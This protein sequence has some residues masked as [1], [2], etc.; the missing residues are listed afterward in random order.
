[1]AV[2]IPSAAKHFRYFAIVLSLMKA[3]SLII[4]ANSKMDKEVSEEGLIIVQHVLI[5][6]PP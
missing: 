4:R 2:D 5:L 6:K 1:M 3:I